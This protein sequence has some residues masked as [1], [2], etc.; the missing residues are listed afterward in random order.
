MAQ[1]SRGEEAA[2]K[3]LDRASPTYR[4]IVDSTHRISSLFGWV[5]VPSAAWIDEEGRIVRSNEGVY[6]AEATIKFGLGKVRIGS[7]AFA[8]AT[9]DWIER[10]ADSEFVWSSEELAARRKPVDDD[11]LLA[12]PTFKLALHFEAEGD[13]ERALRHFEAAQRLAPD[14]WNYNR[15]GWTHK[16]TAYAHMQVLKR[17]TDMRKNSAKNYYD[18]ME[19]PGENHHQVTQPEWIWT[20]AVNRIKNL[21]SRR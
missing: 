9:R 10:G 15:Q 11:T 2:G 20:P 7:E 17:T 14:N 12:E 18:L 6:P 5:N 16:G 1:D 3:W 19:L 13:S 8:S 21:L 4:C